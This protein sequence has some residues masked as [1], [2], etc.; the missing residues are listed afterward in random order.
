MNSYK[1]SVVIPNYNNQNFIGECIKSIEEQSYPIEKII[2]V[3]DC[4]KDNSLALLNSLANEYDNL[5]VIPL[6][7]NGGVSH[8]RNTGLEA[9][10]TPYVTFI[11][12]DDL[13]Y[14]RDKIKNEM[15]LIRYYKEQYGKDIIAYSRI[16]PLSS[17]GNPISCLEYNKKCYNQGKIFKNILTEKNFFTIMRDYCMPTYALKETGGY[18]ESCSFWEDLDLIL[19]LSQKIEF[20]YTD[21]IGTGYRQT[22]AGLSSRPKEDHIRRKNEIFKQHTAHLS[23][24]KKM[25]YRFLRR[26]HKCENLLIHYKLRLFRKLNKLKGGNHK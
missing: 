17:E 18:D 12:S 5:H 6:K 26:V 1:I 16:L 7:E 9:V 13:Y 11:D 21:A 8:A 24:R 3:D 4:S 10:E 20:Y 14:N 25:L 22:S 19:K 23:A 2:V 15:A